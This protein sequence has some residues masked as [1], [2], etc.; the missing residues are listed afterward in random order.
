VD[1]ASQSARLK[2]LVNSRRGA[3]ARQPTRC[4]SFRRRVQ[5]HDAF[6]RG[7]GELELLYHSER[8]MTLSIENETIS[9]PNVLFSYDRNRDLSKVS[10]MSCGSAIIPRSVSSGA[11]LYS[12]TFCTCCGCS[13]ATR[14]RIRSSSSL[15]ATSE[16]QLGTLRRAAT[17]SVFRSPSFPQV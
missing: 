5:N 16:G 6:V 2:V 9:S 4:S 8:P 14:A 7:A 13:Q 3:E 11:C 10:R 12:C 15:A 1:L 17:P